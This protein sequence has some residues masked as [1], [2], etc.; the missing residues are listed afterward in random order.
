M[1]RVAKDRQYPFFRVASKDQ[2][3]EGGREGFLDSVL[4][5]KYSEQSEWVNVEPGAAAITEMA[6]DVRNLPLAIRERLIVYGLAN[7]MQSDTSDPQKYSGDPSRR[8]LLRGYK[9]I[10]ERLLSGMFEK[11]RATRAWKPPV[12]LIQAV[13]A[14]YKAKGVVTTLSEVEATLARSGKE[15]CERLEQNAD[16]KRELDKLSKAKKNSEGNL[17]LSMFG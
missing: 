16:I 15:A 2:W 1:A 4:Q 6:F 14:A 13:T 7:K 8:D 12:T 11:E 3:A 5:V 9:E 17:D 10:W